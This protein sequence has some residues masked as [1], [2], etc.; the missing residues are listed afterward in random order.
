MISIYLVTLQVPIEQGCNI[1]LKL[2]TFTIFRGTGAFRVYLYY[3]IHKYAEIYL[4]D[5][6]EISGNLP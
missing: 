4:L 3:N 6:K 1:P 2:G 5:D